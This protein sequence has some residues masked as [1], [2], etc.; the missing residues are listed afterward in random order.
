ML[1][2]WCVTWCSRHRVLCAMPGALHA[3]PTCLLQGYSAAPCCHSRSL[4]A[5]LKPQM[6]GELQS[7]PLPAIVLTWNPLFFAIGPR[8]SPPTPLKHTHMHLHAPSR[9][10]YICHVVRPAMWSAGCTPRPLDRF[11]QGN[12][13][14]PCTR[15]HAP[16][17]GFVDLAVAALP[18][19]HLRAIRPPAHLDLVIWDLPAWGGWSECS[20]RRAEWGAPCAMI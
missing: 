6:P 16:L 13:V 9:A 7:L 15:L 20:W 14:G 18:Q 5:D 1:H 4:V 3:V 8:S 12:V 19:H 10:L 11:N 17:E 2:Q